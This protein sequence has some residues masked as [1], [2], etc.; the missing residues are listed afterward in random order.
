MN[1]LLLLREYIWK[2]KLGSF[3]HRSYSNVI[4]SVFFWK[5]FTSRWLDKS[6]SEP[7]QT[8]NMEC[9]LEIFFVFQAL[10]IF[11]NHSILGVWQGSE[12]NMSSYCKPYWKNFIKSSMSGVSFCHKQDIL[13]VDGWW[14]YN[15]LVLFC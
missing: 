12:K 14:F 3:F 9:F 4:A 8:S 1:D 15:T 13:Y 10:T 11:L 2:S 6:H 7:H 5:M